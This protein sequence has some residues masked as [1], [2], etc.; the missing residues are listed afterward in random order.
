MSQRLWYMQRIF[1][2]LYILLEL[3]AALIPF[4]IVRLRKRESALMRAQGAAKHTAIFSLFWEQV[5]LCVPGMIIGAGVWL[6][7]PGT[8]TRTGAVLTT[9]F[10]LLWLLGSGASAMSLSRGSVRT[11]LRAEE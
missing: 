10:T 1:P 3:L 5:M 7:A 9:L 2:A 6:A 4:I 11:I 8:P